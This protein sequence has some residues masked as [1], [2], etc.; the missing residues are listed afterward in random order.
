METD[1]KTSGPDQ[2]ANSYRLVRRALMYDGIFD[3]TR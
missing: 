1:F 3:S 2:T